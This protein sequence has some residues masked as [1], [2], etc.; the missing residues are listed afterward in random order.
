MPPRSD[1]HERSSRPGPSQIRSASPATE[2]RLTLPAA[3]VA[4][5]LAREWLGQW[6][7]ERDWDVEQRDDLVLAV[8]EAVSNSV[9]HGY[10]V[11]HAT[12]VGREGVIEVHGVLHTEPDG[13]RHLVLTVRDEGGWLPPSAERG[14]R[15]HGIPLMHACAAHVTVEGSGRGTT[16]VLRSHPMPPHGVPG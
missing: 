13:R 5:S 12:P 7:G 8:S 6:L 9:E 4:P 1:H 10:G 11:D 15:R 16:V 14:N 2:L 3:M